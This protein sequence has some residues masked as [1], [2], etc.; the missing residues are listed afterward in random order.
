MSKKRS[1][2]KRVSATAAMLLLVAGCASHKLSNDAPKDWNSIYWAVVKTLPTAGGAPDATKDLARLKA[3]YQA[4]QDVAGVANLE[5]QLI[6]CVGCARLSTG[7]PPSELKFIFYREHLNNMYAFTKA[8]KRVQAT[9]LSDLNFTLTY[10]TD[11]PPATACSAT[12]I[13]KYACAAYDHCDGK[14]STS[15]CDPCP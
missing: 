5:D 9:A 15:R 10:N 2:F 1:L 11:P 13:P 8:M 12:C 6:G 14:G 3:Y 4:L 7:S